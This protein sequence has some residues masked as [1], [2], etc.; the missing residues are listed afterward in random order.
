MKHL[1]LLYYP[2]LSKDNNGYHWFPFSLLP[3]A[4]SLDRAGY[5]VRIIDRRINNT[6]FSLSKSDADRVLFAGISAMS[7]YQILDGLNLAS[8]LKR[9]IPD[10]PIVWGGWHPT[11]LPQETIEHDLVNYV[12]TGRGE[13]RIVEFADKLSSKAD[14]FNIKGLAYK[15]NGQTFFTGY[16]ENEPMEDDAQC[17]EKYINIKHYINEQTKALGYF[18]GH[19]CVYNCGFCSRHFMTNRFTPY[20]VEKVIDDLILLKNK[21][22]YRRVHFQD[23]NFFN[24]KKRALLIAKLMIENKINMTWAANI[25]AN[26]IQTMTK[27]DVETLV[28]SGMSLL[29]VG[30]ESADK[31]LLTVVNKKTNPQD[32]E[33][34]NKIISQFGVV[35]KM[36]YIL[37]LPGDNVQKLKKT[38]EQI[39]RIKLL[40]P[41]AYAFAC[42]Y[43][44]YPGTPLYEE[45]IKCGYNRLSGL[46]QWSRVV[47]QSELG[48][49]PWLSKKEM[50]EYKEVYDSCG[51]FTKF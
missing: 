38:I 34:T 43:Q 26:V 49:I 36:S 1:I 5:E 21:Y 37:G 10:I 22:G 45:S 6:F 11:I 8:E 35:L 15:K 44:P 9:I 33:I 23:D 32:I 41:N 48:V 46:E 29:S 25:R 40:N 4:R 18:S 7:G 51:S 27:N 24:N 13:R 12:I 30:V 42:F 50:Y 31:D 47:P 2:L 28:Q 3:L 16:N 17:Y 20:A 19:G 39:K 14:I